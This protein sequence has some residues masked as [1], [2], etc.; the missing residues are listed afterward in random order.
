MYAEWD[1]VRVL[2]I[3]DDG[4][5]Q[6]NDEILNRIALNNKDK[7][8]GKNKDKNKDKNNAIKGKGNH[9]K[10]RCAYIFIYFYVCIVKYV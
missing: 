10:R 3:S 8:K 7:N 1:S 4:V 5:C 2:V 9:G 6:G